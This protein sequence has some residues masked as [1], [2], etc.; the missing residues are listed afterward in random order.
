[1]LHININWETPEVPEFDAEIHNPEKVF[2]FLCYRG[3][4]YAKW[5][6]LDVLME[7]PSWFL[8]NPRKNDKETN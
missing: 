7:S 3:I 1:M 4:H 2:A 8:N 5:V 6:Y